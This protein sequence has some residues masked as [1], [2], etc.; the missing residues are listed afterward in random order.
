MRLL[1]REPFGRKTTLKKPLAANTSLGT[2]GSSHGGRA[3]PGVGTGGLSDLLQKPQSLP[4][5]ANSL[6]LVPHPDGVSSTF[7]PGAIVEG[8]HTTY[9]THCRVAV[10]S[11]CELHK[12]PDPSNTET[13]NRAWNCSW[14]YLR[15]GWLLRLHVPGNRQG[16]D[17]P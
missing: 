2:K 13:P 8:H 10:G 16:T 11:Y 4:Q 9:D 12:I 1:Q 17:L 14:A 6:C 7:S 5:A 15:E 3:E